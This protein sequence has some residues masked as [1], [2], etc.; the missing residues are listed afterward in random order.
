[1]VR[2]CEGAARIQPK[3][4]VFALAKTG[5]LFDCRLDPALNFDPSTSN[6]WVLSRG[7]IAIIE[8]ARRRAVAVNEPARHV[9]EIGVIDPFEI[10]T[11]FWCALKRARAMRFQP[12][13]HFA[14]VVSRSFKTAPL[15]RKS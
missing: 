6:F 2:K 5:F 9:I 1:M 4:P 13:S 12:P 10:E 15:I 8:M 14:M 3:K 7:L 11:D